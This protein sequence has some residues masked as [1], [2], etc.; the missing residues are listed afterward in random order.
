MAN[1]LNRM[2]PIYSLRERKAQR[3]VHEK[4]RDHDL[5]CAALAEATQQYSS[6]QR[7]SKNVLAD[8][9]SCN[10]ITALEA[11]RMIDHSIELRKN[12]E[13]VYVLL[14]NL[15]NKEKTSLKLLNESNAMY[16]NEVYK[17]DAVKK[18]SKQLDKNLSKFETLQLE[19]VLEDEFLSR[20][21]FDEL[22]KENT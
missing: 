19:Q 4:R 15:E 20:R 7:E 10:Q 12:S 3:L 14:P 11:Q 16:A 6:L 8:M 5:A 13:S 2:L 17:S 21:S 1:L 22:R 18:A 9:L